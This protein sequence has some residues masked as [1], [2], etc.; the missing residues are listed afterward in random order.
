MHLL[1]RPQERFSRGTTVDTDEWGKGPAE[2]HD[3]PSVSGVAVGMRED[4]IS[5]AQGGE[6]GSREGNQHGSFCYLS[7]DV[8]LDRARV[9]DG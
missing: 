6:G 3:Y 9:V 8:S 2:V 4:S 1:V 7:G 5:L